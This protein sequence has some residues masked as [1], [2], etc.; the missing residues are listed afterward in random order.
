VSPIKVKEHTVPK[1]GIDTVDITIEETY[2]VEGLGRDT[3]QLNGTLVAN[4][5]VP[6]FDLGKKSADWK[7][8]AVVAHFTSLDVKGD[9]NVFGP[10]RAVL[11]P[12][13]PSLAV[14]IGGHCR[15]AI[16]IIVVMPEHDLVLRTEHPVQLQSEV[17]TVP[18]IGD[19]KTESVAPVKLVDRDSGRQLGS[20]RKARV[21]W[22]E[23]VAQVEHR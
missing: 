16:G 4:R 17:K 3:V 9:S 22:R 7:T 19:E 10:V 20:L 12:L 14:V 8:A 13:A 21:L 5:T 1:A 18:P 23:L 2:E 11:D 6:L 15:A